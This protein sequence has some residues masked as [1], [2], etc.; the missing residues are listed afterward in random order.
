[1]N[2]NCGALIFAA[3]FIAVVKNAC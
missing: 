3:D 2:L 1:M